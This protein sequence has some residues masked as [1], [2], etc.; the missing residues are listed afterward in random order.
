MQRFDQSDL[1]IF[2]KVIENST[3]YVNELIS[4]LDFKHISYDLILYLYI[5]KRLSLQLQNPISLDSAESH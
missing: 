5:N 1:D 4:T 3:K 2:C